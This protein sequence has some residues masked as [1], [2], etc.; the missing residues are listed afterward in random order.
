M[1]KGYKL[2]LICT[3][4]IIVLIIGIVYIKLNKND[5]YNQIK[6]L[7]DKSAEAEETEIME[8]NIEDIVIEEPTKNVSNVKE[9]VI[10]Q[11]TPTNTKIDTQPANQ[12]NN[13]IEKNNTTDSK[14]NTSAANN[15]AKNSNATNDNTDNSK[16]T[17][18]NT[19]TT[20]QE[21]IDKVDTTPKE[22]K[23]QQ[24]RCTNNSNHGI[25]VGNVGKW[26]NT[27]AD[28]ITEYNSKVEYWSN[29]W[30]N[31]E[32]DM[33]TY[34]KNCPSGYQV[35]SCMFCGKWSIDYYYY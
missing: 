5:V 12:N 10:T 2:V 35:F 3:V 16:I 17:E 6:T 22:E 11:D 15:N 28:A 8:S 27:K 34:D 20:T 24:E 31:N 7:D 14:V 26:Y 18:T 23:P 29:K 32:I 25:G 4:F 21:K 13:T 9:Q 33:N 19:T 1:S 30:K